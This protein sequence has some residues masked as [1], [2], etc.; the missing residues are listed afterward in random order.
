MHTFS[1]S[2]V[3]IPSAPMVEITLISPNNPHSKGIYLSALVDSGADATLLPID[4]LRQVQARVV[5]SVNLIGITGVRTTVDLYHVVIQIGPHK[6]RSIKAVAQQI[7]AEPIIGRD[8]LNH[9]VVT[10]NG[11]AGVTEIAD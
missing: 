1:Y 11:L 9:L 4:L 7:G 5:E 8:V 3:Y 10:L 6:F 2:S